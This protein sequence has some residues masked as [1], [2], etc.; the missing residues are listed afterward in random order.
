MDGVPLV[1]LGRL[2]HRPDH[3]AADPGRALPRRGRIT[4]LIV[5]SGLWLAW[6]HR[7]VYAPSTPE[8][9]ALDRY[10][11]ALDPV[12]KLVFVAVPLVLGGF[13]GTAAASQWQNILLFLH[14]E[15]FGVEDPEFGLD[16]GFFVFSLPFWQ[17]LV[18]Y[19]TLVLGLSLVGALV[20]HYIYGGLQLQAGPG[21]PGPRPR[22]GSTWRSSWPCCWWSAPAGTGSSASLC[23]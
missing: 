2:P 18:S 12:R 17:M 7:P 22:P 11:S 6:R 21:A 14:R 1:R 13:T 16:V 19:S 3:A 10:R 9:A 15:P 20:T 23:R 5:W 8:Q 4:A